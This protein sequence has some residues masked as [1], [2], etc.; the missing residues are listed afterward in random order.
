M[1]LYTSEGL[2]RLQEVIK[3]AE[4]D[5]EQHY[6]IHFHLHKLQ[7]HN[8][9][10]FQ[11]RIALNILNDVFRTERGFIFRLD[12]ADV[13]VFYTG[14]N[15]KL[16]EKAIFQLRY[17][18]VEDPL[19][20]HKD[21][22]ENP[23]FSHVY[24]L[25]LQWQHVM[26]AFMEKQEQISA[27][28][29]AEKKVTTKPVAEVMKPADLDNIIQRLSEV[30]FAEV[31]RKQPICAIKPGQKIRPV[32]KEVYNNMAHLRELLGV[33]FQLASDPWLFRYLLAALDDHVLSL[34]SGDPT[35]HLK[36]PLALN[37]SIATIISPAF[38]R[39]AQMVK[40]SMKS[41]I[42]LEV[43]IADIFA[44]MPTY[45]KAQKKANDLGYKLCID[46]LT[47][48]SFTQV[49]RQELGADLIKLQWNAD[50]A[51]DLQDK[52]NKQLKEKIRSC[53]SNR[54]ILCRC[55]SDYAIEYGHAL[56]ITLFQGR[57][58]DR[59]IDPDATIIN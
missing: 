58:P 21:G 25:K 50:V 48:E 20:N 24:D 55:D 32:Y 12:D 36:E 14:E 22:R 2:K 46:G 42:I 53:G 57:Y 54:M 7:G 41:S 35:K 56:G 19:A 43:N 33:K 45:R 10:D 11:L 3:G 9:T 34:L 31:I 59:V 52:R 8:K 40:R 6:V 37:L 26:K 30:N 27:H 13:F 38:T 5:S 51:G 17:L 47:D 23:D 16:L 1:K 29:E 49:Q 39:F 44:D 4:G 15:K 18:F 28:K